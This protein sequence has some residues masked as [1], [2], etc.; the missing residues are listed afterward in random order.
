MRRTQPTFFLAALLV[1]SMSACTT[2]QVKQFILDVAGVSTGLMVFDQTFDLAVEA[3]TRHIDQYSPDEQAQLLN[4]HDQLVSVRDKLTRLLDHTESV[5]SIIIAADELGV[6]HLQARTA[7]LDARS[8]IT[9]VFD[10]LPPADQQLLLNLDAHAKR[11]D[12]RLARLAHL[13]AGSDMTTSVVEILTVFTLIAQ[14]LQ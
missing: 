6:L 7:Y 10:T 12:V 5:A 8:L 9:P 2:T 11:L 14:A 3:I 4:I 1:L 13:P